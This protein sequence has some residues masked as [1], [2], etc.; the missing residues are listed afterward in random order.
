MS[1]VVYR[2]RDTYALREKYGAS[3]KGFATEGA[4][5]AARTRHLKKYPED[6]ADNWLVAESRNFRENIEMYVERKNLMSGKVFKEARNT[7]NYCSPA[8]ES[9]WSM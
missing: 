3:V 1:Y 4:A 8:S 6:R 2:E 7:P 9:Y 5:K